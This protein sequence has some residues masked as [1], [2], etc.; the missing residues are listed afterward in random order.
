[1]KKVLYLSFIL[2]LLSSAASAQRNSGIRIRTQG[3]NSERIT[4]PERFQIRR[5]M[6]RMR[7]VQRNAR[8]DGIV[9]PVERVRIHKAKAKTRRDTFRFRHNR[10]NRII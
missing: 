4:R 9:T 2:L 3:F 6:I 1:M 8:R 10:R 5:D 7:M